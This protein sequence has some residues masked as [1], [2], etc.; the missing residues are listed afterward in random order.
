MN[1][2]DTSNNERVTEAQTPRPTEENVVNTSN[3]EKYVL[4]ADIMGFKER[5]MRTKHED[6]KK[7]LKG[8]REELDKE[9]RRYLDKEIYKPER[10]T[11]K[12]QISFFSDSILIVE[13]NTEFGFECISRA[14]E[15]LM[16][17]SCGHKFPIKG[18]IAKGEFTYEKEEQLF[19]GQAIIDAFLL[20]EEVHYYGIVAHHTMEEDIKKYSNGIES[21]FSGIGGRQWIHPYIRSLIPLKKGKTNHYHL[22]CYLTGIE[23]YTDEEII[24]HC[25][26]GYCDLEKIYGTVSGAPRIY[27][28][29]TLQVLKDDLCLYIET[30]KEQGT[31]EFPLEATPF[32]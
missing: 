2:Q 1:E 15:S 4:Y 18:A 20:Q 30:R 32:R 5:V 10:K 23:L 31:V 13:E 12:A 28:D 21:F 27:V 19:F 29:N 26:D 3:N 8:L 11:I 22:A 25:N 16:I 6:L 17:I 24:E 14:A 9:L 7:E